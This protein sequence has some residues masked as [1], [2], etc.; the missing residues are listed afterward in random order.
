MNII[1]NSPITGN[2]S[3]YCESVVSTDVLIIFV[4]STS[5]GVFTKK[6]CSAASVDSAAAEPASKDANNGSDTVSAASVK[7]L[8]L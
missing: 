6:T 3:S 4:G 7:R 5:Y 2:V 1:L 8:H